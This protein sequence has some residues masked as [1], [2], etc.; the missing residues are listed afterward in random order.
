MIGTKA[1]LFP[2]AGWFTI[3]VNKI[4]SS[5]EYL[6]QVRF[7]EDGNIEFMRVRTILDIQ[8][9]SSAAVGDIGFKFCHECF[10]NIHAS[11]VVEIKRNGKLN[12]RFNDG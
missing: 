1:K 5:R 7:E 4:N 9:E 12:C 2:G 3:K 8:Q 6:H 11:K 10:R